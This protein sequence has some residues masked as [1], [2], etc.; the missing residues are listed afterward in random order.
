[1]KLHRKYLFLLFFVI[2]IGGSIWFVFI[3]GRSLNHQTAKSEFQCAHWVICNRSRKNV[4]KLIFFYFA[5]NVIL[6]VHETGIS[7]PT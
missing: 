6:V 4:R 2:C 3:Y 7:A 5:K 1:M